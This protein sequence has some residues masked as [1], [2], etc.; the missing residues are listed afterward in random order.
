[1]ENFKITMGD[2]LKNAGI[3]G[4]KYMLDLSE[5][6]EERDYGIDNEQQAL[7]LAPEF[8]VNADWTEMYFKAFVECF[9]PSTVYQGVLDRI[10]SILDKLEVEEWK[11]GKEEKDF[12]KYIND[13][14]LS[15]SYQAGYENIKDKIEHPEIYQELKQNK[16]NDKMNNSELRDRL[17][18]LESFLRQPLCKET[19]SM[20]SIVYTYI[21]RFWDGKC[22]LLR[23]NAKKDMRELFEKEFSVPVREYWKSDHKK[24]KELCIDCGELMDTKEKVSIAFMKEMADDL[25]RKRSAFWNCKV[26][27]FLCPVCAYVYA[28]SP[29][30]FQLFANKFMFINTNES[31]TSLLKANSKT[32]KYGHESEKREEEK[33]SA[34]FARIMNIILGEKVLEMSNIQVILRGISA[35]DKYLLSIIRKD[36]LMILKQKKVQASLQWLG[37]HPFVKMNGEFVNVHEQVVMN[38]FQYRNQYQLLNR[39]LKAALENES[40]MFAAYW[41]YVIQLWTGIT[42]RKEKNERGIVM[43]RMAMRDNG[44]ELRKAI[45]ASKGAS[46]DECLRGTVYQLLNALSVKNEEKFIDIVIRLYS[47]SKLLM[48]DGFVYMLGDKER[49]QEYG[50]AFVLGLKGSYTEKVKEEKENE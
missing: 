22:F 45:L 1:M 29:L 6:K 37:K 9:G 46:N 25:T 35:E 16:L 49:F 13:K 33:Y 14:L 40:V 4:M 26:D 7:W 27:A 43:G 38:I 48:P 19:F 39:L 11:P 36:T 5:A 8:A 34:W 50:Y 21:N 42:Q 24:A 20:K 12:L 3:V 32:G 23:A 2:F 15:N 31:L 30:G 41:V 47:S 44:Y 18:E 10:Q 28:L 17:T